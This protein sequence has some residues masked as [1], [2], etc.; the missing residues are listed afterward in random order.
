M[1]LK[2]DIPQKQRALVLQ[3]RGALGAYESGAFSV[4]CEHLVDEDKG[5]NNNK[6]FRNAPEYI[7]LRI[8]LKMTKVLSQNLI[9]KA[10]CSVLIYS[11]RAISLLII[12][13]THTHTYIP[14]CRQLC[15]TWII[16]SSTCSRMFLVN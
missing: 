13:L 14:A 16:I 15:Y 10:L 9:A 12:T 5:K 6:G 3:G 7:L 4:L 8:D 11:Y 1:S 2:N